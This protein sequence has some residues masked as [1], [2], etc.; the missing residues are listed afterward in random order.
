MA[1]PIVDI[2]EYR[3][4]RLTHT[5]GD[6]LELGWF[7]IEYRKLHD[8][9]PKA[10]ARELFVRIV[11]VVEDDGSYTLSVKELT[12]EGE[13][14]PVDVKKVK[15]ASDGIIVATELVPDPELGYFIGGMPPDENGQLV[16]KESLLQPHR[17]KVT[18]QPRYYQLELS[19][20][21]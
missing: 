6:A 13:D 12:D 17:E 16:T 21:A 7:Y 3:T 8:P 5:S 10:Y 9:T 14:L 4:H 20:A 11:D 19:E 1:E 18:T 2:D 15:V